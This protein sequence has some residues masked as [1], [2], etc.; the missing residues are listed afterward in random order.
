MAEV[1]VPYR[2]ESQSSRT[3]QKWSRM[4]IRG[5]HLNRVLVLIPR[6]QAERPLDQVSELRLV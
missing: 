6:R 5:L 4:C 3:E 1:M 2:A